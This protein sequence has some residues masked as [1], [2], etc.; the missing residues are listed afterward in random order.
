MSTKRKIQITLLP[1]I[2]AFLVIWIS[3]GFS[4]NQALPGQTQ[5][6]YDGTYSLYI[7]YENVMTF[8]WITQAEQEG[9]Y[10]LKDDEG[11]VI[12]GGTTDRARV[13]RFSIDKPSRREM[14]L[15]FG[16]TDTGT[17]TV[18]IRSGFD[19]PASAF[20]RVDSIYAVG[21]V[22]GSY[23]QL[24]G[25]L[26]KARLIDS[27]LNWTGGSAHLVFMGDIFDRGDDVTKVLWLIHKLELQAEEAKG[28][29]HLLL[30]NHEIMT[31]TNDLRYIGRKEKALSIAFET[32]YDQMFHPVKSYLGAWLSHKPP[33]IKIDDVLFAHGGIVDLGTPLIEEYNEQ[34]FRYITDEIFPEITRE[35]ADSTAYDPE[36]WLRRKSFFY[37]SMSPYWYRGYALSDTLENQLDDMLKKYSSKLHVVGHTPF[38]SITQRYNGKF[39]TT[40]L[41]EKATELLFL[42]K[43]GRKYSRFRIDSQGKKTEL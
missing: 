18:R 31:M 27:D 20:R 26:K 33:V 10:L 1:P 43:K 35:H 38:D 19:R 28:R 22:H 21:D 37:S 13:H 32:G 41:N 12:A 9:T 17:E 25:L 15:E 2:L 16:G 4:G 36:R 6:R 7:S 24:T 42:I 30:G 39:I 3:T 29:V 23:D 40:D 11:G 5:P 8:N 14:T 34:A